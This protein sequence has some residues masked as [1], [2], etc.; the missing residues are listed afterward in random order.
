MK[1][2]LVI[3]ALLLA[4]A[5]AF[6]QGITVK[7]EVRD[8]TGEALAGVIVVAK[9]AKG[10]TVATV[11]TDASGKYSISCNSHDTLDFYFL[12]YVNVS[13]KVARTV[14]VVMF[15]DASSVLEEAVAIGYGAVKKADLTGSVT[16]V[17][18]GEIRNEPVL[19]IDQALQGRVAGLEITSADGEPGSDSVI[20]IRGSRS[21]PVTKEGESA[22]TST[23]DPL[24]V[25]DGVADVV[26][27][28]N[29]IN[30]ADIEAISVLK[31]ASATA[32]YGARGANGVIIITTKGNSENAESAQNFSLT[33]NG[34]GGVSYLPR[35]LDL[36][37]AEQYGIYRNEYFQHIGTSSSM[38]MR[39]PL[40]GL[41]VKT[42]FSYGEGTNWIEDVCRVAPY[43]NYNLSMNGFN[44]KQKFYASL[45]YNDEQGIIKKS[46]KQNYT[47][48][49]S[50]TNKVF[51]WLT[52]GAYLR[53][54][55]RTQ[56]NFLTRIGGGGIYEA[57]Q[58]LSPLLTPQDSYNP[59][60]NSATNITNAVV[61]LNE[62]TDHTDR[63]MLNISMNAA[64]K[65]SSPWRY[66]TKFS[67]YFFDRQRYEYYP[68]TL[69]NRT[70]AMGG[71]A[72]RENYGEQS[73]YFEQ[74]LDYS[75]DKGRNH[76]DLMLG[77]TFKH[78]TTH[79][80]NLDGDGYIVDA[81]KWNNMGAVLNKESYGAET[82]ETIK[83]KMAFFGRMNYNYARRYYFTFTGRL[84]G[85]SN[86]AANHKWGFFPSGAFK[87]AIAKEPWFRKAEWLDDFSLKMSL[88]QSGNDPN[89]AYNSLARLESSSAGYPF[90][91]H[92]SLEYRQSR[93]E[94]P[95]LSWETTTEGNIALDME[96]FNSKLSLSFEAYKAV[97]T[98]LLLTVKTPQHTGYDDK[99]Q[100]IGR[101][102][103]KGV[104]FSMSSRNIVKRNFSWT[105]SFTISHNTS[106]VDDLGPEA[107]VVLRQ[108]PAQIAYTTVGYRVGYP[109]N[110]FWGFQYAGVWHNQEEIDRN[111]I[112]HAYANDQSSTK[113]GYPIFIDQN[114]DGT[115]DS[116]DIVFLGSPDPIV[117]GG[118]QNSFRF[119]RLSLGVYFTY[120]YGGKVL[121]YSEFYMAGSRR[122]NQYAYMVNAWHPIANPNSNLP[123]AGIFDGS[124]LPS[125]FIIH[126]SSYL[127]LKTL[128]LSY[129]F[130][131][132]SRAIQEMET[133]I[134]GE[135]LAL[136]TNYN[137]FDPDVSSGSIKG[138]DNSWYP[139][140][141]RFVVSVK[142]KY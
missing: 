142:I 56:D 12:G 63:S 74:T 24:I 125:S 17:K 4:A 124:A 110:S 128:S 79:R 45:S 37:N 3:I 122:T 93:I 53:Y 131:I 97:T 103:S 49:L 10:G 25:V 19:S 129:R 84:D 61:R 123:R 32:I 132:K 80:F 38:D 104:E 70:D 99:Y 95:N 22:K 116:R 59:L 71:S 106:M 31:D 55:Y 57:A 27:S 86:F 102:T 65:L 33:F 115:L 72:Y 51:K 50:V 54:Q 2:F 96:L 58:Y 100:N 23:N 113:L 85:A 30:P 62:N 13:E 67:Y 83:D 130:N 141:R 47:G 98:D 43:Q 66:K 107:E 135:N 101:T 64:V 136:W 68:S 40:S 21:L 127:R 118:L 140:S 69:P 90:D 6:A 75:K 138:Y 111:A 42:P 137:G 44:G 117:Y 87:W 133:S 119:K 46:G 81:V 29:D 11:T 20:R 7:G 121:N 139:K 52:L 36:M 114:H 105:S 16:N 94:S 82:G 26:S 88:G 126:D 15:P 18:M 48:S 89:K 60:D 92:Y 77:Q 76:M 109:I 34:S 134:S 9:N 5:D 39:T 14:N 8:D 1:K 73:L 78:L 120:S 91:G 28:L 112:T 41:S 108:A 35:N